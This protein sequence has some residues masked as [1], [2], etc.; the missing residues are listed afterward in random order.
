[1]SETKLGTCERSESW[2][3]QDKNCI[4]WTPIPAPKPESELPP[5]EPKFPGMANLPYRVVYNGNSLMS[6]CS[7]TDKVVV[8]LPP[9]IP[10]GRHT[11]FQVNERESRS[12]QFMVYAANQHYDLLGQLRAALLASKTHETNSQTLIRNHRI[13]RREWE[14]D[15]RDLAADRDHWKQKA[16]RLEEALSE[17][18]F[19]A[20][21]LVREAYLR[22]AR[23]ALS[24]P[25]AK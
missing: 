16:E 4:N 17:L 6:I 7:D 5:L 21:G 11:Y 8:A 25:E 13:D 23:S 19:Y 22:D 12:L 2:H 14:Q 18:I 15:M 24:H 9:A 1:M 20:N 10:E 3:G